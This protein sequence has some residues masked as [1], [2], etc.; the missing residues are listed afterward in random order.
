MVLVIGLFGS[1]LA[2]RIRGGYQPL[3]DEERGREIGFAGG[4]L[5]LATGVLLGVMVFV[6][7]L[8]TRPLDQG[9]GALEMRRI[10]GRMLPAYIAP[11]KLNEMRACHFD[12][13]APPFAPEKF[14]GPQTPFLGRA[15]GTPV[16]VFVDPNCPH[17]K[18][19]YATFRRLAEKY[20]DRA[21]FY[22]LPQVLWDFSVPPVA[23]LKLAEKSDKYFEL[24]REEL[25]TRGPRMLTVEKLGQ[26]Y[27]RIGLDAANLSERIAAVT[28]EVMRESSRVRKAGIDTAPTIFIGEHEVF[29]INYS[30]ECLG[31]L[32]EGVL[33]AD[34]R[35][36]NSAAK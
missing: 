26:I 16:I 35:R 15:G 17:C 27:T 21:R 4:A 31:T 29:S 34:A 8:G 12:G 13:M 7:R 18:N 10:V 11:E 9:N 20:G 14:V 19:F 33:A 28:P 24:W 36:T 3:A 22:L 25:A 5:F 32:I 2:I 1:H 23:A 6:N 30:E